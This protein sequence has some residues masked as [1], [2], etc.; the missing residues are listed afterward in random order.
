MSEHITYL[1]RD[2]LLDLHTIAVERYGGL[3]GI[4]SQDRLLNVINAPRQEMFGAE[5]YTDLPSKAAAMVFLLVKSA[6]FL[7]ANITTA[8]FVLLRF[9]E[10]NQAQ[11]RDGTDESELFWV[12]RSLS[13]G[14][15]DRE[16]LERWLRESVV[17]CA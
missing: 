9:L 10:I 16:G 2:D 8:L 11:L 7:G 15:L 3:L 4:A 14:D 5:V 1:S 13:H 12:F 17:S 6:P